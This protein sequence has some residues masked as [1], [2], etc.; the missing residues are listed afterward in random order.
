MAS[1][2]LRGGGKTT[3]ISPDTKSDLSG[4]FSKKIW[5][6]LGAGAVRKGSLS[7]SFFSRLIAPTGV[8]ERVYF[9]SLVSIKYL[10][11]EPLGL[12]Q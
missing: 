8:V 12:K 9:A 11:N 2:Y 3:R 5:L 10:A 6:V 1:V 4:L 7:R